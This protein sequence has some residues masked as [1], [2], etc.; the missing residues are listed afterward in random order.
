VSVILSD[1][2]AETEK[3]NQLLEAMLEAR[4]R[5]KQ[6]ADS[7]DPTAFHRFIKDKT[8]QVRA[9]LHCERVRFIIS[10]EGDKVKFKATKAA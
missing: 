3:V 5:T 8:Q 6:A 7:L 9:T 2:D 10:V 4:K 1:P